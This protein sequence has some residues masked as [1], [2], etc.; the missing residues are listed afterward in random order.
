MATRVLEFDFIVTSKVVTMSGGKPGDWD[1]DECGVLNF[2]SR[3]IDEIL[4]FN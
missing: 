2:A 4:S 1:C 3:M